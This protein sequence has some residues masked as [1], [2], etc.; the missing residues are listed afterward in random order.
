[1]CVREYVHIYVSESI[2]RFPYVCTYVWVFCCVREYLKDY[3][4]QEHVCVMRVSGR[5]YVFEVGTY[6]CM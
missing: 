1:M 5:A 3:L 4:R 2:C 6:M